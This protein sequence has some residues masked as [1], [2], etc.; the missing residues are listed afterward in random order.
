MEDESHAVKDAHYGSVSKEKRKR[1][2]AAARCI[3]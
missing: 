3:T 2:T 1:F